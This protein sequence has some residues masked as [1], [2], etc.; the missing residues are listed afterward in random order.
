MDDKDDE[1]KEFA[2]NQSAFASYTG[3]TTKGSLSS[4]LQNGN[5][6][7]STITK[8]SDQ[9]DGDQVDTNRYNTRQ[10][11][12]KE[13]EG[14]SSSGFKNLKQRQDLPK[15][16][17]SS[18]SD[19][20]FKSVRSKSSVT[21]RSNT[22]VKAEKE[23]NQPPSHLSKSRVSQ[24]KVPDFDDVKT[25]TASTSGF[26]LGSDPLEYSEQELYDLVNLNQDSNNRNKNVSDKGLKLSVNV[27][28]RETLKKSD[29]WACRHCT[30]VNKKCPKIC[31]VCAKSKDLELELSDKSDYPEE[32][33]SYAAAVGASKNIKSTNRSTDVE[34]QK[35]SK[36]FPPLESSRKLSVEKFRAGFG[37]ETDDENSNGRDDWI[38]RTCTLKNDWS[39]R[40][41]E[42]CSDFRPPDL[43]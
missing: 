24:N 43:R 6:K 35:D 16:S 28:P 39:R 3:K 32:E 5:I 12:R 18:S 23:Y 27:E 30:F 36:N 25:I 22:E 20:S 33:K 26:E 41:C 14:S 9:S 4:S 29:Y 37:I 2:S 19:S 15:T 10:V 11:T 7:P 42:A 31:E 8:I 38:C 34:I 17:S 21:D 40:S 1:E 13:F